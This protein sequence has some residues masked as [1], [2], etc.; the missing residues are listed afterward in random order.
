MRDAAH[1]KGKGSVTKVFASIVV[2]GL[3]SGCWAIHVPTGSSP[4]DVKELRTSI[5]SSKEAVRDQFGSPQFELEHEE[6]SHFIY[7][8]AQAALAIGMALYLPFWVEK[9][10]HHF[11]LLCAKL[12]F[13]SVGTLIGFEH[14]SS[15]PSVYVPLVSDI[16]SSDS[17][18]TGQDVRH[19]K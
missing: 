1:G 14:K 8:D 5:G 17:G 19:W 16:T 10:E 9:S 7:Q 2:A 3:V 13:D 11:E 4:V 18:T 12:D 6:G 15:P